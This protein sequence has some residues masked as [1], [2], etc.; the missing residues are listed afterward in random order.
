MGLKPVFNSRFTRLFLTSIFLLTGFT[1]LL[2]QSSSA[3]SPSA[4]QNII[5]GQSGTVPTVDGLCTSFLNEYSDALLLT[6]LTSGGSQV[7][8]Y[9][10][11]TLT[12]L[13]VC[14]S[15]LVI[16]D[17]SVQDGPNAVVY[18]DR[19]GAGGSSTGYDQMAFSISYL[20]TVHAARGGRSGF[21]GPDP[22]GFIAARTLSIEP[23]GWSAEFRISNFTLGGGDWNRTIRIAMAQQWVAHSGDDYGFP[24][25][26]VWNVPNTW[27]IANLT[28][29]STPSTLDL[30]LT[31]I[32][33]TQSIQ[34][35]FQSV[36][37]IAG[38]R[39]FVRLHV[40]SNQVRSGVSARLFGTLNGVTMLPLTPLNPG[41]V[42][43]ATPHPN[44]GLLNDALLFELPLTWTT[45]APLSLRA[46]LNPLHN[47][48]ESSYANNSGT[49]ALTFVT[50]NPLRVRLYNVRYN[51]GTTLITLDPRHQTYLESWLK[52]TYPISTL[53]STRN[54][55]TIAGT[56]NDLVNNIK[57]SAGYVNGQLARLRTMAG[58]TGWLYVGMVDA[59]GGF[60]RGLTPWEGAWETS[61]PAGN[62]PYYPLDQP[63]WDFDG[64]WADWYGAHEIG[65]ALGRPHVGRIFGGD[66]GCG[67]I[68]TVFED[69]FPYEDGSIGGHPGPFNP[70]FYGFDRGDPALGVNASVIDPSFK[71]VMGYCDWEWVSDFTY[72]R[73]STYINANFPSAMA[74]SASTQPA[75]TQ[76]EQ[77]KI[78]GDFLFIY[79]VVNFANQTATLPIVSRES[80]VGLL[81]QNAGGTGAA[82]AAAGYSIRLL[83][84]SGSPLAT[85]QISP[86]PSSED[87]NQGFFN[88][89]VNFV[90]G[91]KRISVY[92][93]AQGAEIGG[94]DVSDHDPVVSNVLAVSDSKA[95]KLTWDGSDADPLTTLKYDLQYSPD[96]GKIWHILVTDVETNTWK[97]ALDELDGTGGLAQGIFKVTAND[98]V[99]T[100]EALSN[101]LLVANKAPS[102]WITSPANGASYGYGQEV[103][104]QGSAQDL[105]DGDLSTL[106][107]YSSIDGFLGSGPLLSDGLLSTGVHT[108]TLQTQD[109]ASQS[110]QAQ[111]SIII[112]N[113]PS[114]TMPSLPLLDIGSPVIQFYLDPAST[115]PITRTL[116]IRDLSNLSSAWSASSNVPWLSL[117]QT[118]GS[119]PADPTVSVDPTSLTPGIYQG[120]IQVNLTSILQSPA[121]EISAG[122]VTS[123]TLTVNLTI[124]ELHE[125]QLFLPVVGK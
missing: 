2:T 52:R 9:A 96:N 27:E 109:S 49:T 99:R 35:Y 39:T 124:S 105:E 72:R 41:G 25:G 81:P 33:V 24:S 55:V 38:K 82:P 104:F 32:E 26:Y 74:A 31:H 85:Y 15:G 100:G 90:A 16:P 103:T 51:R 14:M 95:V 54:V 12:D 1:G 65:H 119:L 21:N 42:I 45:G 58:D 66:I 116:S 106:N 86:A 37:L 62:T 50:A 60:I 4:T 108:I 110:A 53:R 40:Q 30:T 79:G 11:H 114:L 84:L 36:P 28:G 77:P 118:S 19:L 48:A 117:G 98:G 70:R 44:Q 56:D 67:A 20:G 78:A 101:A 17:V 23:P 94:V 7:I 111:V 97:I 68:W 121:P 57:D 64:S 87:P 5:I 8:V 69:G 107:W 46:E 63:P 93:D 34:D 91:T 43:V 71:D 115:P 76:T 89:V 83:D 120:A 59:S 75:Q 61:V 125:W 123:R 3:G 80:Q 102:V 29:D 10:K 122:E 18:I 92:S 13:Y 88:T 73:I 112:L 6:F 113:D 22:G 47:P